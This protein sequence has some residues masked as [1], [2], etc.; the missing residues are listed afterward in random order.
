MY[1]AK[2]IDTKNQAIQS[3]AEIECRISEFM[4]AGKSAHRHT[5]KH[6]T[7]CIPNSHKTFEFLIDQQQS[8]SLHINVIDIEIR[9]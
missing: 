4:M 6:V 2:Q 8:S 1:T 7:L 9:R 3:S 5:L